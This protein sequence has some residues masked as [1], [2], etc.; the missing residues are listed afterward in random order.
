[1]KILLEITFVHLILSKLGFGKKSQISKLH[2]Y[3]A[4]TTYVWTSWCQVQYYSADT[5]MHVAANHLKKNQNSLSEPI[6][7][8]FLR[9]EYMYVYIKIL[10][11]FFTLFNIHVIWNC[12]QYQNNAIKIFPVLSAR[13]LFH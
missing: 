6:L 11:I 12:F 4:Q 7:S 3:F 1:M 8:F 10:L 5:N 2:I 13:I 9:L